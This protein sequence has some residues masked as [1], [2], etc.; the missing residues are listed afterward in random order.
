M[1]QRLQRIG[2]RNTTFH[3]SSELHWVFRDKAATAWGG[4]RLMQAFLTRL[5][6]WEMLATRFLLQPLPM[7]ESFLMTVWVTGVHFAHKA[8][9]RFD[10][11]LCELLAWSQVAFFVPNFTRFFLRFRQRPNQAA[12]AHWAHWLWQ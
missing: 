7:V 11:A 6:F 2:Q 12:L 5:H 9:V 4:L 10:V 8:L 3:T 1:K